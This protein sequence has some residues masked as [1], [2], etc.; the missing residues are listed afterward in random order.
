MYQILTKIAIIITGILLV[1]VHLF[2]D[3]DG[4]TSASGT[5]T[6]VVLDATD[7][8]PILSAAI[9]LEGTD[10]GITSHRDGDFIF[11]NVPAG[12]QIIRTQH[13]GYR[14]DFTAV[15]VAENDTA[16]VVIRL[17]PEA[18][19][20]RDVIV[21]DDYIRDDRTT[22]VERVLTGRS[23]RQQLGRTIAETLNDEPGLSQRSMG[24]APARPVLRG[25]GGDRLLILEDGG[26]TGDLSATASDHA[27]AIEP[28]TAEHIELLRGPSAL[29][30]GGNTM[31]GVINVIRGQIPLDWPDHFHA[32]GSLQGES[33]NSGL[34]G[35]LRLYGP[36]TENFAF[37]MD[38]SIRSSQDI[39][40][41]LGTL[42]NT[43]IETY[44]ASIGLSYIRPWGII[45]VSGNILDTSY[46]V[47]GGEGLAEAHP[48]GVNIEMFRRYTEFK[49]RFRMPGDFL[50]RLD[51]DATYSFY[52]H[53][54]FERTRFSDGRRVIGSEFG[55]LT[56]NAKAHMHHNEW[57]AADKGLFGV[58]VEHR[59][60]ASG[61]FSETPATI[62]R[63]FAAYTF[64]EKDIGDWNLQAA[65]RF[66]MRQV[67]PLRERNSVLIGQIRER[68]FSGLSS[69]A[70]ALYYISSGLTLGTSFI[71][72]FRAPGIEELYS[73]GPHLANFSFEKGNPNLN[74]ER[75]WGTEVFIKGR[76]NQFDYHLSFFRN[77]MNNYIFP[78][79]EGRRATRRDD[80]NVFLFQEQ[81][82]LMAGFELDLRYRISNNWTL[83]GVLNYVR[84]D[85]I[86]DDS[87]FPFLS[88]GDSDVSV[89][90]M[91]PLSGRFNA[92]WSGGNLRLGATTRFAAEQNRV[93]EFEQPTNGYV[94]FDIFAQYNIIT[95][96][97][98]HTF[99]LNAE[100]LLDTEW[101]NH[102][103]RIK[104]IYPE[105]GR[106]I[107]L[108]YRFYF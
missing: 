82:V 35:G 9:L 46:G 80:L 13:I 107:R 52:R 24:P 101:R 99:S 7:S 85:F 74:A 48:N 73:E 11:R 81:Q 77:Q 44:N 69:S 56:T 66:D 10:R 104:E 41:P 97:V 31:G 15:D 5:I 92:E 78:R 33:V 43:G 1:P 67:S 59:D 96:S 98:L 25:L 88:F 94:L 58:W 14:V 72:S 103:S 12:R 106:N 79:D 93:D 47:P 86:D 30:H 76:T 71:T 102:L 57:S 32:S 34:A 27:L 68:N 23:L 87:S 42:D 64:Q 54:E 28:M 61:A 4:V 75:G 40:T 105:P 20:S 21:T 83:S 6:G 91:P 39:S 63:A 38:G 65:L 89:P 16:H 26:R 49:S 17:F 90:M 3:N 19:R 18:V 8:Q 29:I 70:R 36:V 45:G 62:E 37:R 51:V 84:G 100:N 50:S 22:G 55:V 95:G 53:K 60:Y 2:G 108:L